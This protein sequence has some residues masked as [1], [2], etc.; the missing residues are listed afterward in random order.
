MKCLFKRMGQN[1][2]YES[3]PVFVLKLGFSYTFTCVAIV[4]QSLHFPRQAKPFPPAQSKVL[5]TK[6]RDDI[7]LR[8]S[9]H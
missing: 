5:W 6:K 4:S 7:R 9:K 1:Q 2:M 8:T 3:A